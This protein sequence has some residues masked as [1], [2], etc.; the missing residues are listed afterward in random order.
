M[1]RSHALSEKAIKKMGLNTKREENPLSK[2]AVKEWATEQEYWDEWEEEI[3]DEH[4][5]PMTAHTTNLVPFCINRKGLKLKLEGG[6]LADIAPT[7]LELLGLP[8]PA[9][10]TGESLIVK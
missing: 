7:M 8:K 3:L 4:D 6:K 5:R 10:M 9:E 1:D 2:E